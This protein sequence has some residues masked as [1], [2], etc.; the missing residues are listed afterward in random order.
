[1]RMFAEFGTKSLLS[2]RKCTIL[3]GLAHSFASVHGATF[4]TY[5][6]PKNLQKKNA[7]DAKNRE[8]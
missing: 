2:S 4:T 3:F 5:I 7:P 6:V 1:M 8:H